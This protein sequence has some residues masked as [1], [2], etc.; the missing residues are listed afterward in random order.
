MPAGLPP[1]TTE[2]IR[3]CLHHDPSQRPSAQDLTDSTHS[4]VRLERAISATSSDKIKESDMAR[5]R[6]LAAAPH[7]DAL[8]LRHWSSL[9]QF[10]MHPS[11]VDSDSGVFSLQLV[12]CDQ[13]DWMENALVGDELT[14][15]PFDAPSAKMATP[16][17]GIVFKAKT[18]AGNFHDHWPKVAR[19]DSGGLASLFPEIKANVE[20]VRINGRPTPESF[21]EAVPMLKHKP[22]KLEFSTLDDAV[23]SILAP[24]KRFGM[25]APVV[26]AAIKGGIQAAFLV[27]RFEEGKSH[28]HAVQEITSKKRSL[29]EATKFA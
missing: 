29:E 23:E 19:V 8:A 21:K 10:S 4:L 1:D 24:T 12:E 20:L 3:R 28:H 26:E 11:W 17:L 13:N 14:P 9:G 6:S 27:R 5:H 7:E 25:H 18:P 16:K 2:M 15:K 22:C